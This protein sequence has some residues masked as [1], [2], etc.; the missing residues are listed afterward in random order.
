[1][2]HGPQLPSRVPGSCDPQGARG[3]ESHRDPVS[4]SFCPS[5]REVCVVLC[6][7]AFGEKVTQEMLLSGVSQGGWGLGSGE[8]CSQV[9]GGAC[10]PSCPPS[11]PPFLFSPPPS[12]SSQM[13]KGGLSTPPARPPT[14]QAAQGHLRGDSRSPAGWGLSPLQAEGPARPAPSP[15][16][17]GVPGFAGA[18]ATVSGVLVRPARLDHGSEQVSISPGFFSVGERSRAAV[19]PSPPDLLL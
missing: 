14:S 6:P 9:S 8:H 4:S 11:L 5:P 18:G 12:L 19:P 2:S 3:F 15:P 10:P 1:M 7:T 16:R 17:R 13:L